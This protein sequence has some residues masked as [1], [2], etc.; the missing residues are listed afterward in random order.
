LG[1]PPERTNPKEMVMDPKGRV[2]VSETRIAVAGGDAKDHIELALRQA[3]EHMA[4]MPASPTKDA[5]AA[6]LASFRRALAAWDPYSSDVAELEY[7]RERVGAVLHLAKT[8]SPTVRIR[9]FG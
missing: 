8:T 6:A 5:I 1:F 9:R 2:P 7:L 4:R 3:D